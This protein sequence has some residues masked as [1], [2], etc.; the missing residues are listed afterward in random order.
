MKLLPLI[1]VAIIAGVT[2]L[3]EDHAKAVLPTEITLSAGR[4]A[5]Y[6]VGYT[7]AL[8]SFQRNNPTFTG[9]VPE[10]SLIGRGYPLSAD[11]LVTAGNGIT[12]TGTNGR[13][14]TAYA[15]LPAG[16]VTGV[17]KQTQNDASIGS[18]SG[19]SWTSYNDGISKPLAIS[20]TDGATVSVIQIGK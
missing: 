20:V 16:A 18:V 6:F 4:A 12:A 8:Q 10:A 11:F 19:S 1:I 9:S 2:A 14:V 13:I 17:L 7:K 5:E 3:S 15:F